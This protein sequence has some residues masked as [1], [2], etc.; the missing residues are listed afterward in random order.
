MEAQAATRTPSATARLMAAVMPRSLNEP[1]GLLPWC[2]TLSL[3]PPAQLPARGAS[4]SGVRPSESETISESASRNSISSRNRQT[5]LRSIGLL[6]A[7]RSMPPLA[8]QCR[9]EAAKLVLNLQKSTAARALMIDVLGVLPCTAAI[10]SA[11]EEPGGHFNTGLPRASEDWRA[12]KWY[13]VS[14][15]LFRDRK[16]TLQS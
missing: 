5:P 16:P 12:K 2:L 13:V 1:V 4:R 6:V 9:V 3:M 8:R 15:F 10:F 7:R 11:L 14:G